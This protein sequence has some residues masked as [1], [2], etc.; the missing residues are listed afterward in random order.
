MSDKVT[1]LQVARRAG[2]SQSAVSRVFTPGASVSDKTAEKVRRA[3]TELGYRPNVL[4]R[5]MASGKSGIIGLVVARIENQF[6]PVALGKLCQALQSEGY[7]VLV[8]MASQSS[9]RNDDVM[10]EILDYQVEGIVMASVAVSSDIASRCQAA[11]VPVV[12]F[13]RTQEADGLS[14]VTSDN[15]G[16][17]RK[18]ADF[19][20][21]AGHR[22]F[23]YIAG[24][25]GASTQR[26]REAGFVEGLR[27]AGFQ[28]HAREAG[29]FDI[30]KARAAARRMFQV[31][32]AERPDAVFVASDHMAFGVMDVL[33]YELGLRIP[34]DVSVVGYDDAP[35][36][37]W[38]A[39]NLTTV[40]QRA[41]RMV[42]E[43]VTALL[44]QIDHV[45]TALPHR[46]RIDGPLIVRGS[47][48][49]PEVA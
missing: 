48:R 23:G 47:A 28:L 40:R 19:L 10:A 34:Q 18:V 6:Y 21:A 31:E 44:R 33:R 2:V 38:Q 5:A 43:T 39:Y 49:H 16:G 42:T 17:G 26:D 32:P 36:A 24:W 25:A 30:E 45:E 20:L 13:N 14:S 29:D 4:A 8:F 11:G 9:D 3:A 37:E 35:P 22:R 15:H 1:S 41:D 27:D 46:V 7:H 12:L